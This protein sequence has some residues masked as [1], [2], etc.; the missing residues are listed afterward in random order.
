MGEINRNE[1][2]TISHTAAQVVSVERNNNNG[3][4]VSIIIINTSTTGQSVT[5]AIDAPAVL[6]AGIVLNAGGHWQDSAEGGYLPTQKQ[7][8]AISS[9]AGATIAIQERVHKGGL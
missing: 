9:A 2:I 8:T 7:I 4:R 1:N 5:L 3:A 6:N